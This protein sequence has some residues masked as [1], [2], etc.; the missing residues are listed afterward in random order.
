MVSKE[1]SFI[2]ADEVFDVLGWKTL[3]IL[4]FVIWYLNIIRKPVYLI[5]FATWE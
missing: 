4:A 2:K 1:V 5:D 3:L